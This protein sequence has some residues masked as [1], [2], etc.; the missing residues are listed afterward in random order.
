[1]ISPVILSKYLFSKMV[2]NLGSRDYGALCEYRRS[3]NIGLL[4]EILKIFL[5]YIKRLLESLGLYHSSE[6][7]RFKSRY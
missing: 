1:M 7:S 2:L 3:C 6:I 4:E 5:K